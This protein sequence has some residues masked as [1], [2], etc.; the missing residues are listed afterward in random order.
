MSTAEQWA[1]ALVRPGNGNF[2]LRYR[3]MMQSGP[4]PVRLKAALVE[5]QDGQ[6]LVV[7]VTRA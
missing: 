5:E 1:G 7:G 4:V 2:T 6:Q 3:L